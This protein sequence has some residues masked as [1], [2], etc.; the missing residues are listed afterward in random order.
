MQ[1]VQHYA[2]DAQRVEIRANAQ[3]R[4]HFT[5]PDPGEWNFSRYTS[6]S[7][8]SDHRDRHCCSRVNW[9]RREPRDMREESVSNAI[10]TVACKR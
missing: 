4:L 10:R 3:Q 9:E 8:S 2:I 5:R 1:T 7:F 6:G